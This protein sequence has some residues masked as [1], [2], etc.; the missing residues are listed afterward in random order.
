MTTRDQSTALLPVGTGLN[1]HG[2]WLFCCFGPHNRQSQEYAATLDGFMAL[3]VEH[4]GEDPQELEAEFAAT[5]EWAENAKPGAVNCF[6]NV[7]WIIA[8]DAREDTQNVLDGLDYQEWQRWRGLMRA[9]G[10]EPW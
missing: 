3:L 9:A 8:I 6:Y 10:K 4:S 7:H 1:R 5:R 2:C